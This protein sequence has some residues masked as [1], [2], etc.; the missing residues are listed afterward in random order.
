[1]CVCV[2]LFVC[3][4]F[5]ETGSYYIEEADLELCGIY[6]VNEC[7]T[8]IYAYVPCTYLVPMKVRRHQIPWN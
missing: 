1:M 5:F 4:F 2:G 6:I 8:C 7:F 3:F